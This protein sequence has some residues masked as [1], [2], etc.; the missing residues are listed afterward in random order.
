MRV[1]FNPSRSLLRCASC[2][3][4]SLLAGCVALAPEHE[5]ELDGLHLFGDGHVPRFS[6]YFSCTG[7][8]SA[9]T[10]MCWVPD[11]YFSLWAVT[12]GWQCGNWAATLRLMPNWVCLSPGRAA[13]DTGLDYRVV[14]RFMPIAIPSDFDLVDSRGGY[15]PPKVGYKADLY[16]YA[17]TSGKLIVRADLS[18]EVRRRVSERCDSLRKGRRSRCARLA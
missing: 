6:F 2:L 7:E 10:D 12:A 3:V 15:R 13:A 14:V 11:K 17:A 16:V 4:M 5:R 1:D 9:E 8:V 18:Q